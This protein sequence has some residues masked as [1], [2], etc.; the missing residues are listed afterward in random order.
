MRERCLRAFGVWYES[1]AVVETEKSLAKLPTCR[2]NLWHRWRHL[3][4]LYLTYSYSKVAPRPGQILGQ[5]NPALAGL[6][7][8][9]RLV[10]WSG[11]ERGPCALS[12][13]SV[14]HKAPR[15]EKLTSR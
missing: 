11:T 12:L 10:K 14:K 2:S 4:K 13:Q 15:I 7:I 1:H 9:L 3:Q 5:F 8:T 6:Q